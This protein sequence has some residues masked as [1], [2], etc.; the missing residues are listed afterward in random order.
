MIELQ[1]IGIGFGGKPLLKD[2]CWRIGDNDRVGLIGANGSGKT[3][4]LRIIAGHIRSDQGEVIRSK[5]SKIGYLPQESVTFRGRL[6]YNEMLSVFK[7]ILALFE[8]KK[9]IEEKLS[10]LGS[11][12]QKYRELL[13]EYGELEEEIDKKEGYT[14]ENK[15]EK[16]LSGLGFSE[17][18]WHKPTETFSGGW[19]MR[20]ALGKLLLQNPDV[21]LLDE[22]TNFLDI[23]SIAWLENYL[24]NFRGTI[25]LVSHDRYFM[26]KIIKKIVE[27]ELGKLTRYNTNYSGYLKEKEKRREL[28]IRV[29]KN[30]QEE[31]KRIRA[32]IDKFRANA[33]K[34]R[35]VK[36]REKVLERMEI[37][38][39]PPELKKVKF[40]FPEPPRSG[41]K[42]LE[43]NNVSQS[44]GE[45]KVFEGVGLFIERGERIAVVGV[46]GAGKSTLLKILA[47][48]LKSSSGE[49]KLGANIN[50]GYFAQRSLEMLNP[51]NTV[52]KELEEI[53]PMETETRLRTLA[54]V[55][56][57]SGD[58]VF[59]PVK[60]LSGGEKTRLAIAKILINPVNFLILDEPTNH[61]D[62]AGRKV[63]ENALKVYHGTLVLVTHD[64][65]M[66]DNLATKLIE[67]A[68]GTI[69]IHLGNYTD[70]VTRK[71]A[72]T[73]VTEKQKKVKLKKPPVRRPPQAETDGKEKEISRITKLIAKKEARVYELEQLLLDYVI[74]S[75]KQKMRLYTLEYKTLKQEIDE[76]YEEWDKIKD[77]S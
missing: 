13:K 28:L 52:L 74:Y 70:Y 10:K 39:V 65:C 71:T 37:V 64:R 62:L 56:L 38:T 67:V 51:E 63:L 25:V 24:K 44:Y 9:V 61:L 11:G 35:L 72:I 49:R 47:G 75:D 14:I 31:I 6:L 76:L 42:V 33:S 18:D 41:D 60:V 50:I 73:E 48:V 2:V 29:Y 77:L 45:K 43:L 27:L 32:F 19:E 26:D 21:L 36:S 17:K 4:I 54:G 46:N 15:I 8:T 66:I 57:F 34:A 30:Q 68:D 53:A 22:P 23:E 5:S 55:F 12:S 59:K 3:T 16:V 1:N 40:K 58:D 69:K 7:P 20:I